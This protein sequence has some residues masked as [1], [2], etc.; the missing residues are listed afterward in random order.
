MKITWLGHAC[1]KIESDKGSVVIDPYNP[2]SIPGYPPYQ[3]RADKVLVTHEHFD[4][5][6][7]DA[8]TLTGGECALT[9]TAVPSFHDDCGG[10]ILG[11]NTIY[12]IDDGEYRVAHFGDLGH[13]LDEATLNKIGKLDGAIVN[14][15]GF[16]KSEAEPANKL[17][18]ILNPSW[19]FPCHF[20]NDFFGFENS[21]TIDEFVTLQGP[22]EWSVAG[23]EMDL[24]KSN[25]KRTVIFTAKF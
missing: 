3:V 10:K 1:F 17:V 9:I 24:F 21:G 12:V 7:R 19:I 15:G 11:E 16:E 13:E 2:D 14:I 8:V 6:Y 20:K 18:N 23:H 5:N 25:K 22:N 4:H